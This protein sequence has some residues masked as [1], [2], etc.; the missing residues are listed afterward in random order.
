MFSWKQI[1]HS[2]KPAPAV[3]AFWK[4]FARHE[5]CYRLEQW[6]PQTFLEAA[7]VQLYAF[8]PCLKLLV[9]GQPGGPIE[10]IVTAD[11]DIALFVQVFELVAAAPEIEGWKFTAL[12]QGMGMGDVRIEMDDQEFSPFTLHF[13]AETD[14]RFPDE[15]SLVLT[16][17][18]YAKKDDDLFQSGGTI[19]LENALGELD[20]ALKID[21]YHVGPEPVDR[22]SLISME[23]LPAYLLWREKEAARPAEDEEPTPLPDLW[24]LLEAKDAEGRPLLATFNK[25]CRDWPYKYQYPWVVVVDLKYTGN[26]QGWPLRQQWSD[27]QQIEDEI[28]ALLPWQDRIVAGR[29]TYDNTRLLYLYTRDYWASS[30]ALNRYRREKEGLYDMSFFIARDR[31]WRAAASF[32]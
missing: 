10:L 23:R 12:K 28:V 29:R 1:F 13:Y 11:G 32:F 26:E 3:D 30:V 4:W 14:E 25:G 7:L 2:A 15:V 24:R 19:Y 22:S 31:Y 8:D 6:S 27:M 18:A 17:P 20:T 9:G 5:S 16:H 21:H